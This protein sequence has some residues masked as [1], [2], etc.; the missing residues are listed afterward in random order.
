MLK[1]FKYL[2]FFCLMA[3]MQSVK[4]NC[5]IILKLS[6]IPSIIL[7]LINMKCFGIDCQTLQ[8]RVEARFVLHAFRDRSTMKLSLRQ[9]GNP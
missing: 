4:I 7:S 8:I 6:L 9:L 1:K 5:I 3:N 2:Q